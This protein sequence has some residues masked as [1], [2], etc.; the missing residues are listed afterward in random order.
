MSRVIT[1]CG[2]MLS[3]TVR[4]STRTILS[5]IGIRKIRPGPFWSIRRPRRKIT[6]RSYSRRTRIAAREHD[7][8]E[9]DEDA[10]D[11]QGDGHALR[12]IYCLRPDS[13]ATVSVRPSTRMHDHLLPGLQRPSSPAG[14]PQAL[15]ARTRGRRGR[16][17][18]GPRRARR[19]APPTP[20]WTARWRAWTA[21]LITHTKKPAQQ[22][23]GEDHDRD[24]DVERLVVGVEQQQP[25][26]RS[27]RPPRRRPAL[28]G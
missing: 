14:P 23:R 11:R 12:L 10:D 19:S 17:A 24:G 21:L 16:A 26:E 8:R 1:S 9:E 25:A 18:S 4:R 15:P 27:A 13:G 20:V 2:G 28:H 7:H 5:M 6:P 3:V 22:R